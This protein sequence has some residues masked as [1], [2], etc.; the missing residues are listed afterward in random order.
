[1]LLALLG[2]AALVSDAF[3]RPN[4]FN[5]PAHLFNIV[6]QAAVGMAAI[7]VILVTVM[8]GVDV[9]VGAGASRHAGRRCP[10]AARAGAA[11]RP[12]RREKLELSTPDSV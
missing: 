3:N 12:G 9:S 4:A 5:R 2:V 1:V 8:G 6:R 7:G 10:R 11:R